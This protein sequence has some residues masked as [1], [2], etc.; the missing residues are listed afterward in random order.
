MVCRVISLSLMR[1]KSRDA[2]LS[3]YVIFG[4]IQQDL[5]QLK[6]RGNEFLLTHFSWNVGSYENSTPLSSGMMVNCLPKSLDEGSRC[7]S[8]PYTIVEQQIQERA[9]MTI[10][11]YS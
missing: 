11:A 10:H 6:L 4:K 1:C 3:Q 7:S 2:S 8:R 5:V 9:A